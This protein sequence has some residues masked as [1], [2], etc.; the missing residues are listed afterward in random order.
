VSRVCNKAKEADENAKFFVSR[1]D[2]E[3]VD[4]LY[5][6]FWEAGNKVLDANGGP[7]HA[8]ITKRCVCD[9]AALI[10]TVMKPTEE[11]I[12]VDPGCGYGTQV[13]L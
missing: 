2:V 7:T 13:R 1:E 6:R 12:I 5:R 10:R 11:D 3:S 8:E 4:E 9:M